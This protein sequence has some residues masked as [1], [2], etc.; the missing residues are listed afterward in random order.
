MR[1]PFINIVCVNGGDR[2]LMRYVPWPIQHFVTSEQPARKVWRE[3]RDKM[4]TARMSNEVGPLERLPQGQAQ[5]PEFR[6]G[7]KTHLRG[8]LNEGR[9]RAIETLK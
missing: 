8:D 5:G 6:G 9:F 3:Y 1:F 4:S 2:D 7:M